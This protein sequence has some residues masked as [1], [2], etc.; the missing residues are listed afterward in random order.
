MKTKA[1]DKASD[2]ASKTKMRIVNWRRYCY[3]KEYEKVFAKDYSHDDLRV[4]MAKLG[5]MQLT[6]CKMLTNYD[7]K[8]VVEKLQF[9]RL[10]DPPYLTMFFNEWEN[11]Q[12]FCE[13]EEFCIAAEAKKK[14]KRSKSTKKH[15]KTRLTSRKPA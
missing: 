1:S 13:A 9:K 2:K 5:Y 3:G 10:D 12:T 6:L 7:G 14:A 4:R 8:R 11:V 15:P